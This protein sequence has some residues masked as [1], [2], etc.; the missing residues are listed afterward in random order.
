MKLLHQLIDG[1]IGKDV[2]L[3][4]ASARLAGLTTKI[5]YAQAKEEFGDIGNQSGYNAY[6]KDYKTK[7]SSEELDAMTARIKREIAI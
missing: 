5:T 2:A 6:V 7:Y 1:K 3:V 4:V